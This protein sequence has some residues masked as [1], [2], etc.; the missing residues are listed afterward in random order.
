MLYMIILLY[1][2]EKYNRILLLHILLLYLLF[3]WRP[4]I[5]LSKIKIYQKIWLVMV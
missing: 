1:I 4:F 3:L 2:I 5:Y